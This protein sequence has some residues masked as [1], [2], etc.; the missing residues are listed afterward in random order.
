MI[1]KIPFTLGLTVP[2]LDHEGS[3]LLIWIGTIISGKIL[4]LDF[5]FEIRSLNL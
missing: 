1:P 5:T 2:G 3:Q 4:D